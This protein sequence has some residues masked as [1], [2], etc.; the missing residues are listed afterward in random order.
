MRAEE[1]RARGEGLFMEERLNPEP[2]GK[3]VVTPQETDPV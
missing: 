3:G 2:G 1:V